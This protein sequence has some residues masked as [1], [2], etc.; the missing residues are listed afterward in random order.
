MVAREGL[1]DTII[2]PFVLSRCVQKNTPEDGRLC[3]ILSFATKAMGSMWAF[4]L[5]EEP[6]SHVA[7]EQMSPS[8]SEKRCR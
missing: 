5:A 2:R 1:S 7:A 8:L 3:K 6:I 4:C